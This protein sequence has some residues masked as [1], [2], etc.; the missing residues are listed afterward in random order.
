L[1]PLI[2]IEDLKKVVSG[3]VSVP[4][5]A[6]DKAKPKRTPKNTEKAEG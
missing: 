4:K 5:D 2:P 1:K 6:A 3:L